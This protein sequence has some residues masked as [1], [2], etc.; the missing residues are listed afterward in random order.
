MFI[1][2]MIEVIYDRQNL[3]LKPLCLQSIIAIFNQKAILGEH[4]MT[5]WKFVLHSGG[6]I[7]I[8][9]AF[10]KKLIYFWGLLDLAVEAVATGLD[11][12][13]EIDWNSIDIESNSNKFQIKS[14]QIV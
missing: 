5:V 7:L 2:R 10:L 6:G 3:Y 9:N 4:L 14:V 8:S 1:P 13:Y 11:M 12:G